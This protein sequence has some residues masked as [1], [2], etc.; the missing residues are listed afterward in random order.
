VH[1]CAVILG[2]FSEMPTISLCLIA[3]NEER[4][5]ENCL[6]SVVDLVDE[7]IV[8][9]TGST[10]NTKV[11][12][13]RYTKKIYDFR[14]CDD[15]AAARNKALEY[16]TCDWILVLDCDETLSKKDHK[17]IQDA[18]KQDYDAYLMVQRTYM[19]T[20]KE[21]TFVSSVGDSYDESSKFLGWAKS[22][23]VRLFRRGYTFSGRIHESVIPS[24]LEAGGHIAESG[25]VIHHFAYSRDAEYMERKKKLYE[26]LG[27]LKLQEAPDANSCFESGKRAF[28][29]GDVRR[30]R[31]LFEACKGFDPN[32]P[33]VNSILIAV[34]AEIGKPILVEEAF[35]AALVAGDDRM[36]C[37]LNRAIAYEKS[38][39]Y[40]EA[41]KMLEYGDELRDR[42]IP[43]LFV[44][45]KCY[46]YTGNLEKAENN[47]AKVLSID[48]N[49][50]AAY[51]I[52]VNTY[53]DQGKKEAA[54]KLLRL[55]IDKCHP[56]S[57][58]FK[59]LISRI[60]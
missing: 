18:L 51:D 45:G 35:N 26:K 27:E 33:L 60:S 55:G 11:I 56:R 1:E 23:I 57:E 19:S 8:V 36:L 15:F 34:Y 29:N 14:W 20:S 17:V 38:G 16:S 30:A 3:K 39:Q 10:D 6:K 37:Y 50:F 32:F 13:E 12:A 21:L 24:V 44:L 48:D 59:S 31:E 46:F 2:K 52:L 47:L 41:I 7:I 25:V 40:N 49:H 53:L 43:A 28:M 42:H 5:L 54:L 9:D 58:E 4:F 22:Q